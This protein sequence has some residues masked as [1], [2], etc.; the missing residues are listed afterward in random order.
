MHTDTLN[1]FLIQ[2]KKIVCESVQGH[3]ETVEGVLCNNE[4]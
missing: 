2:A 3:K 4:V 1:K